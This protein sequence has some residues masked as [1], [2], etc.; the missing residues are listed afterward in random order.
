MKHR[1]PGPAF[2]PALSGLMRPVLAASVKN[3][4]QSKRKTLSGRG[5]AGK[6]A[7]VGARTAPQERSKPG[8]LKR[9]T[10]FPCKDL[11]ISLRTITQLS[12]PTSHQACS[13]LHRRHE[14]CQTQCWRTCPP[15]STYK[16][17]RV[18]PGVAGTRLSWHFSPYVE[19][20]TCIGMSTSSRPARGCVK[21][22]RG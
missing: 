19:Q 1:R 18:F 12:I 3:M 2:S 21:S 17:H 8:L 4:H 10:P 15:A 16:W 7:V 22:W 14:T 20:S 11:S 13:G 5:G 9:P 6:T